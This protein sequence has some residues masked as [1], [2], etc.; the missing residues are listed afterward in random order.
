MNKHYVAAVAL[1]VLNVV[2]ASKGIAAI[3]ESAKDWQIKSLKGITS[4]KYGVAY[5]PGKKLAKTVTTGLSGVGVPAKS[6]NLKE[7]AATPL[8]TSEGKV[9][10]IVDAREK[11]QSWVGLCVE[12]KSKLDRDPSITY[13][14]ETYRIGTLCD[15]SKTESVVK[16]LCSQFVRDFK[17]KEKA[18]AK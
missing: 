4:I 11:N 14:A 18:S 1:V 13:Q 9:K 10:V 7:D 5:D 6:V 8:S 17:G 15:S 16:D 3:D 12:Q 2:I